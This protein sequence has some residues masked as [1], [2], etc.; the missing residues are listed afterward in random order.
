MAQ[1]ERGW[2]RPAAV[3]SSAAFVAV[4]S[5]AP[6]NA[7]ADEVSATDGTPKAAVEQVVLNDQVAPTSVT[8]E[9]Q[10]KVESGVPGSEGSAPAQSAESAAPKTDEG[11]SSVPS[12]NE[13]PK[14]DSPKTEE[15]KAEEPKVEEAAPELP[16]AEDSVIG[17]DSKTDSPTAVKADSNKTIAD[18]T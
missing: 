14:A 5:S 9:V 3:I 1:F 6:V 2:W 18:G 15:S 4:L 11:P 10:A 12:T 17:E 7:L 8:G 13:E 16:K